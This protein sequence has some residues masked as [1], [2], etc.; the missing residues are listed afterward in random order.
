MVR[1][2]RVRTDTAGIERHLLV[3][4]EFFDAGLRILLGGKVI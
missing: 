3:A 1:M 2:A 4:F